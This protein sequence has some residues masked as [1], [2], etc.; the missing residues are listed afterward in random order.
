MLQFKTFV[1]ANC[2]ESVP[3]AQVRSPDDI[4]EIGVARLFI[5]FFTKAC[6]TR[7]ESDQQAEADRCL[8]RQNSAEIF[9]MLPFPFLLFT[10]E[11]M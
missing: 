1:I 4:C 9:E 11:L 5:F 7:N 3:T 10:Y 6:I 2:S 8:W